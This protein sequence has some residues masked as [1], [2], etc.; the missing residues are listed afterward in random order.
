MKAISL[1][2]PWASAIAIGAKR[3]E[4]RSWYTSYRGPLLIHA[5][6]RM[7]QY[8]MIGYASNWGWRA[9]MEPLCGRMGDPRPWWEILPFG[10]IVARCVLVD[11]R[12]TE[13]FTIGELDLGSFRMNSGPNGAWTERM[14]GNYAPGRFGWILQDVQAFRKP[15]TWKGSQG[16]FEIDDELDLMWAEIPVPGTCAICGCT[17][18]DCH[19][20]IERTGQPCT[21]VNSQRTVCS[22]CAVYYSKDDHL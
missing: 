15:F 20:C 22:A 5:A 14:M 10:A 8:E 13:S 9:A 4:T 16:F 2:Q 12:P 1:W 19:Q 6:K 17:E 3:I 7:F 11:C 21:W 18:E